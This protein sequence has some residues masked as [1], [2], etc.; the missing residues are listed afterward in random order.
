M[1]FLHMCNLVL[2]EAKSNEQEV[3]R[4]GGATNS[5]AANNLATFCQVV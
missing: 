5:V 1:Q 4:A 2:S 3:S